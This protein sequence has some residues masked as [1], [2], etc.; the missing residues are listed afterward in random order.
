M[1]QV[2]SSKETH[3]MENYMVMVQWYLK[4]EKNMKVN[5]KMV[6]ETDRENKQR[7]MVVIIK[8]IGLMAWNTEM[9]NNI[10]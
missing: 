8:E 1:Y 5:I 7:L 10:Q 3:L 9:A 2:L 6:K 4:T